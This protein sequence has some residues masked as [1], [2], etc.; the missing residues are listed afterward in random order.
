MKINGIQHSNIISIYEGSRRIDSKTMPK[1][2]SD[3][4]EI[5][6]LGRDLSSMKENNMIVSDMDVDEIRNQVQNG[7]YD[8]NIRGTAQGIINYIKNK[9]V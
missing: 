2:N 8:C 5:S 4:V 7:T 6:N 3:T 1:S 9:E